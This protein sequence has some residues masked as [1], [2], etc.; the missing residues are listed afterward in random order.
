LRAA[1]LPTAPV[2]I[3]VPA[4]RDGVL[5]A[6]DTRALGLAVVALGGG[7]RRAGDAVDPR[8]GLSQ[9]RPLG[10]RLRAGDALLRLH[11]A[12]QAQAEAAA[13]AVLAAITVADD[14]P[15]I[16]PVVIEAL[17]GALA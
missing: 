5:A 3:D 6:M 17:P 9:V 7:R 4:A 13:Q 15:V 2:S 12:D 1:H 16:G 14:A 11:A 10:S 8:V